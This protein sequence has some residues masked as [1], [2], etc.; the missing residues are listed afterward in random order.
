V[1]VSNAPLR[2]LHLSAA[3][4]GGA[5]IAALRLHE[6]MLALG[7]R[8]TLLVLSKRSRAVG[9]R[10][11]PGV[12]LLFKTR[13][14]IVKA[15]LKLVGRADY[16]FQRQDLSLGVSLLEVSKILDCKPDIVI[17]HSIAHF[18]SFNDV[19]T[20]HRATGADVMWYLMDMGPLT[21]GCHYS[22][23]CAGYTRSCGRCVALRSRSETD[24]SRSIWADKR[25]AL[26]NVRG[27]VLAGSSQLVKQA[28]SSSLFSGFRIERLLL[29]VSETLFQPEKRESARAGL[30]LDPSRRVLFFGAQKMKLRRKGMHLLVEALRRVALE[31]PTD[32][33]R[34]LLI[35]AG[36]S[37]GL[38]R[39]RSLGFELL[40]LGTVAPSRLSEIYAASD[41]FACPSV[42][43]SGPMMINESLMSGTP[44]VSFAV[45][46]AEDLIEHRKN[47]WIAGRGQVQSFARGIVE[48]LTMSDIARLECRRYARE[49]ALREC[50]PGQQAKKLVDIARSLVEQRKQVFRA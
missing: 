43:D 10:Q 41:L 28:R 22:W 33:P 25:D 24:V 6:H 47:G 7:H 37:D 32:V 26:D 30:G 2:I 8:S 34:P 5:G 12:K 4:Y 3:D 45:G 50:L 31:W 48:Y 27:L 11:W 19:A 49:V 21:G 46:V 42:E 1:S 38:D 16:Y 14:L 20:I 40:T 23:Q 39:I 9:V 29:G 18:L 15:C 13:R 35:C 36:E 44:V 17:V